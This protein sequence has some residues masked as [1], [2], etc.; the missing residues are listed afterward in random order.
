MRSKIGALALSVSLAGCVADETASTPTPPQ[1][2][3]DDSKLAAFMG[4]KASSELGIR[5]LTA[6]GAKALRW[7]TPRSAMTMDFRPDRLTVAYD[8]AMTINSARCG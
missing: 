8:D 3:C 4:Q 2:Q 5:I 6:S 1:A 7:G